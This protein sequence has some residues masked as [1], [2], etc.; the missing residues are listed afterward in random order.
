MAYLLGTDE[1]GYAPNLGPLVISATAWEVPAD[2]SAEQVDHLV[3]KAIRRTLPAAPRN[4][5]KP[6][7]S[8]VVADSKAL[9]RP[10]TGIEPLE[11]NLLAAVALWK[12]RPLTWLECWNLLAPEAAERLAAAPWFDGFDDSL[13][14]EADGDEIDHLATTAARHLAA[15]GVRIA[16]MR[17]RVIFPEEFNDLVERHPSKGAALSHETLK[18][19][20]E[21]LAPLECGPLRVVCD[22]HGGRN[23]YGRQLQEF[24]PEHLVE[25]YGEGRS[26][27]I[28]RFGPR[29]RRIEVSFRARGEAMLPTALASMCSKYLRELA[30]RPFN[31]F[32]R[33]R[34]PE[35]RPTAGYPGDSR[36]FKA[37]IAAVQAGL[38]IQDRCLWRER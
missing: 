25:V 16:A 21:V 18:L 31:D 19:L 11:R 24:F 22:K 6:R 33:R 28:Y 14:W 9:Y 15:A 4:G 12:R 26:Q 5:R 30:M 2:C 32:W 3:A 37:A 29:E 27:S 8:L 13:P 36:R 1:A 20:S 10:P 38:G 35:L 34:L 23:F 17:A 7:A